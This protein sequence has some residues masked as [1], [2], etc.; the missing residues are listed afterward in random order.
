MELAASDFKMIRPGDRI[1][2][3]IS[4]G[5]DSFVLLKLLSGRKIFIPQDIEIIAT[6]IDLG[7]FGD[8]TT[9][10]DRMIAYFESLTQSLIDVYIVE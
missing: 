10:I 3:G 2:V 7:F 6:H 8:D 5:A 9:H 4:G 1:I